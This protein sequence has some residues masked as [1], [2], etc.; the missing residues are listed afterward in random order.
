MNWGC[1]VDNQNRNEQNKNKTS[2]WNEISNVWILPTSESAN[3]VN[4]MNKYSKEL[5]KKID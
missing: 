3:I 1:T 4:Q 5:N 2:Q